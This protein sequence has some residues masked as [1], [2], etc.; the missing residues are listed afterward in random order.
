MTPHAA[1]AIRRRLVFP[2]MAFL[3]VSSLDRV[4]I[5]F[6][7]LDMNRALG[8]TASQYGFGAGILFAGFLLGQ[9]PSVLLLQ[10]VG[11]RRWLSGCAILWALGAAGVA[12][13]RTPLE[14]YLLRVTVGL[15]ESGLAPGIVLYLSQFAS[16]RQRA[17][18][19]GLPMVAIPISVVIGSPLSAW[20][21][22]RGAPLGLMPWR[23][24]LIAEAVPALL[25]GVTA[26]FYFPDTPREAG[27]LSR[28]EVAE[29]EADA[30]AN[31]RTRVDNDWRVLRA[32]L[33][34]I[35][36]VLWF[37]LLSGSYG[38]IFWLP[39]VSK[40][41]SG[42]STQ[43]VGWVNALPWLG[44]AIGM[45]WNATHSDRTGE[46]IGHVAVPA[47]FAA[48]AVLLAWQLKSGPAAL[49][50]LL[51]LGT[52]L[53][54]AQGAFWALPTALLTPRTLAVAAVAIN[55]LG[56]TGGLVMPHLIGYTLDAGGGY[57]AVS[58]L[59]AATLM[60]ACALTLGI[61]VL[62]ATSGHGMPEPDQCRSPGS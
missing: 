45:A 24:M 16:D 25:L 29:L 4:N 6:A 18:T 26:R 30:A 2:L 19:F 61:R 35:A 41:L 5:S 59:I 1:I 42:L 20:L 50:A 8:L 54:A 10:R 9:Y 21:M 53:G 27:W 23:A 51:V 52:G 60:L 49:C 32:P 40:S 38:L 22:T 44:A 3:L 13:A 12:F 58:F 14:F 34:W 57:G 62:S 55:L 37:C 15:A 48:V 46:R 36:A 47:A 39:Q 28:Q 7:A 17:R 11:I 33:V 56:S 31:L 43:A